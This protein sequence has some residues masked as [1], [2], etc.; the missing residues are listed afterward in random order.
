MDEINWDDIEDTEPRPL[1]NR[2]VQTGE[3][4]YRVYLADGVMLTAVPSDTYDALQ[5][6]AEK[7]EAEVAKWKDSSKLNYDNWQNAEDAWQR[8]AAE[9]EWREWHPVSEPP[10][11]KGRY[12]VW[13]TDEW[14]SVPEVDIAYW[15][16]TLWEDSESV[17]PIH[18]RPLYW[19]HFPAPP[20]EA[21]P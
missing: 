3:N 11:E 15:H 19:M 8:L 13:A 17:R 20:R 1:Q 21:T 16:E 18:L 9:L 2:I 6:R 14:S 10:K 4:K 12:L 5:A 7:A